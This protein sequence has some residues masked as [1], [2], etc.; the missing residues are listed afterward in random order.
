MHL[1]DV[2]GTCELPFAIQELVQLRSAATTSDGDINERTLNA[3]LAIVDGCRPRNELEALLASQA[4]VT[5][6]LAME[7]LQRAKNADM[8]PQ[9][10]M[11]GNMA[12]RL[13]RAFGNHVELLKKLQ[14]GTD[15]RVVVEHVHVHSGGQAIVGNVATGGRA[16]EK[17]DHQPHAP[18]ETRSIEAS[19]GAPMRCEEPEREPVPVPGSERKE[20]LPNARR[21]KR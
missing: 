20:A 2:F 10:E 5:H 12:V 8:A 4:A 17:F 19:G 7:C 16:N 21:R 9:F 11:G 18:E 13:M 14:R 6:G 3:Y 1:L 15:Q